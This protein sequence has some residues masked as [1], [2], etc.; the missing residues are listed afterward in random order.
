MNGRKEETH[1]V[2]E[3]MHHDAMD[4]RR[5]VQRCRQLGILRRSLFRGGRNGCGRDARIGGGLHV[6]TGRCALL[7]HLIRRG[8]TSSRVSGRGGALQCRV[9]PRRLCSRRELAY[10]AT[11][12]LQSGGHLTRFRGSLRALRVRNDGGYVNIRGLWERHKV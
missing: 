7:G 12:R 2:G 8:R 4:Q 9:S 10:L 3:V 5:L 6:C 11:L 1:R